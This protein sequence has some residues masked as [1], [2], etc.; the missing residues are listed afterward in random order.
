MG[1]APAHRHEDS[2]S[3]SQSS[4]ETRMVAYAQTQ[5]SCGKIGSRDRRIPEARGWLGWEDTAASNSVSL[6]QTRRKQRP[7][8]A[9]HG[10]CMPAHAQRGGRG[11][12]EGEGKGEVERE[13]ARE[14]GRRKKR[15]RTNK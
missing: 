13:I 11:K 10:T 9:C 2:S 6:S 4:Y 8:H 7:L 14:G 15:E 5:C 12:G 1:K 3:D